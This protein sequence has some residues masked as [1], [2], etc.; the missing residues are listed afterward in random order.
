MGGVK[1]TP[2]FTIAYD[3]REPGKSLR[4]TVEQAMTPGEAQ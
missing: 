2:Q 3:L 4:A 1:A